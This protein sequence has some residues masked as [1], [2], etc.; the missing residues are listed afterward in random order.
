MLTP[1]GAGLQPPGAAFTFVDKRHPVM[2]LVARHAAVALEP[3]SLLDGRWW[4][5][6]D[7]V[8][9]ACEKALT[10]QVRSASARSCRNFCHRCSSICFPFRIRGRCSKLSS[11]GDAVAIRNR[12]RWWRR[13][14]RS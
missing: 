4:K 11:A 8:F 9:E 12:S 2:A 13:A 14:G 1:A 5:V 3:D 6:D 7:E 10:A